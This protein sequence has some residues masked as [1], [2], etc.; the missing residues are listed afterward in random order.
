[1][2]NSIRHAGAR[3]VWIA[4][5][6]GPTGFQLTARDDGS[7]ARELRPGGGLSGMRERLEEL[8]GTLT[9]EDGTGF[10]LRATVPA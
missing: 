8:G 2:T 10:A 9:V 1:V 7:G 5:S 3:N 6:A 4:V